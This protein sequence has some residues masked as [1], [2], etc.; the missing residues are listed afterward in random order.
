VLDQREE[1]TRGTVERIKVFPL[2][3]KKLSDRSAQTYE[4]LADNL[5][6]R[7]LE[8]QLQEA[9]Q[10]ASIVQAQMKHLLVIEKMKR[11]QEMRAVQQ[12]VNS[13]QGRVMEVT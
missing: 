11:S 1:T 13:I 8:A 12:Q 3:C 4:H 5:E 10:Q 6:L 9:K 7:I 2:E